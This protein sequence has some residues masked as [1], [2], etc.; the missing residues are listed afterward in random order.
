M[1]ASPNRDARRA[2][3]ISRTSC[4]AL[5][6][7]RSAPVREWAAGAALEADVEPAVGVVRGV[8]SV[9]GR[10]KAA[11]AVEAVGVAEAA[12]AEAEAQRGSSSAT[13]AT[14]SIGEGLEGGE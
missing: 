3:S 12:V 4:E 1:S 9:R 14:E 11:E 5:R 7:D 10:S 6:S 13:G 2:P 8:Y